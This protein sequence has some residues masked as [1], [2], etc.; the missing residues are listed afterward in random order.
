MRL[1]GVKVAYGDKVVLDI[2]R[3]RFEK[4]DICAIIGSNGCGKSTLARVIAGVIQPDS[5][6]V[7]LEGK[8]EIG[9]MPQQNYAFYGTTRKNISLGVAGRPGDTD[10]I[11]DLMDA[12]GLTGLANA[13]AKSLSGG[14]LAR[15]A[16]A[17]TLAGY[18]DVLILDEPTA[19]FDAVS[20]LV[21]EKIIRAYRDE[22]GACVL[23]ITHSISQARRIADHVVFMSDGRICERGETNETLSSPKTA[24]LK[25]FIEVA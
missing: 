20:T 14:E 24:A 1:E 5:G 4:S 15:M 16:L 13:K 22:R 11:D 10:H 12:L 7:N 18:H 3:C 19:A 25:S 9:Y 6:T 2:D 8:R 17:R 21:A 23:I